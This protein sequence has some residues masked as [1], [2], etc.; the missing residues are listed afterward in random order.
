M[1]FR[2]ILILFFLKIWIYTC[3][4][5]LNIFRN[6]AETVTSLADIFSVGTFAHILE[7]RDHGAFIEM[8]LSAYRRIRILEPVEDT[9]DDVSAR[10]LF[11]FFGAVY[12]LMIQDDAGGPLFNYI[13]KWLF[14]IFSGLESQ[15]SQSNQMVLE[16]IYMYIICIYYI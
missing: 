15:Q 14:K 16:N 2:V 11:L 3:E 1:D 5:N 4:F 9:M 10:F 8:I 12:S 6:K 13:S 7:I